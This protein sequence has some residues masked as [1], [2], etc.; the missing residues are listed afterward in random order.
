MEQRV[1]ELPGCLQKN[2]ITRVESVSQSTEQPR[3]QAYTCNSGDSNKTP[4]Y[5]C[6]YIYICTYMFCI[7]YT[8]KFINDTWNI[9]L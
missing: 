2:V 9:Y 3:K 1:V 7:H 6:I 8:H 4:V 5:I